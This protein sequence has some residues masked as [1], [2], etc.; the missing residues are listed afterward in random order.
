MC[1]AYPGKIVKIEKELAL[2]DFNG[3]SKTANIAFVEAGVGDYV[4]VHAGFAIEKIE[5][6][7]AN[8]VYDLLNNNK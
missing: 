5:E 8:K 4:M 7:D 6:E 3:I 2:I 1:L